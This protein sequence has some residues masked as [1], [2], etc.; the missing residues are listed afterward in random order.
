[1][2]LQMLGSTETVTVVPEVSGPPLSAINPLE[3]ATSPDGMRFPLQTHASLLRALL[4]AVFDSRDPFPQVLSAALMRCYERAGWDLVT[5]E[6]TGPGAR[7]GYPTLDDLKVA[8]LSVADDTGYG[9]DTEDVRTLVSL[10]IEALRPGS[11]DDCESVFRTGAMLIQLIEHM[12]L[13]RLPR[14]TKPGPMLPT[15]EMF[16]R[17]LAEIR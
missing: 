12:R 3:P 11:G 10:R 2:G 16:T 1:M 5:G 14:G 17:L 8:A 9:R 13:R 7:P 6:L 15:V 4:L